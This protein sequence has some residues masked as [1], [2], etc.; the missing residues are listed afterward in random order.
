MIT[1]PDNLDPNQTGDWLVPGDYYVEVFANA[2]GSDGNYHLV[3]QGILAGTPVVTPTPTISP[4]PADTVT[5][6]ITATPTVSPTSV[7]AN[8][9]ITSFIDSGNPITGNT[10]LST[11]SHS[12]TD[13]YNDILGSSGSPDVAYT[14]TVTQPQGERFQFQLTPGSGFYYPILYL[15]GP[16]NTMTLSDLSPCYYN[17]P[18]NMTTELLAPGTYTV[19]VDE[20]Y[21]DD[22]AGSGHFSDGFDLPSKLRFEPDH[23]PRSGGD[24]GRGR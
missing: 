6:T 18:V 4:T 1:S 2:G 17:N 23:H 7:A 12:V 10:A 9:D 24:A 22:T 15:L 8:G 5:P 3:V 16:N 13:F 11:D 14:F 21:S 20:Y 19:V